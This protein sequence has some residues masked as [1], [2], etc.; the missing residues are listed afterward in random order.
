M[1]SEKTPPTF[2]WHTAA[3]QAVP[4]ENSLVYARALADHKVPFELHIFPFGRHGLGNVKNDPAKVIPPEAFPN[5]QWLELA[6]NWLNIT[7]GIA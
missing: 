6:R 5:R 1:V 7:F 3:D 4:V 2:L